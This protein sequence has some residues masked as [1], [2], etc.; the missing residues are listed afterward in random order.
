MP[1]HLYSHVQSLSYLYCVYS[2]S[3]HL[4]SPCLCPRSN[5]TVINIVE[6]GIRNTFFNIFSIKLNI[7]CGHSKNINRILCRM[8]VLKRG[9]VYSTHTYQIC[10]S[11]ITIIGSG[12]DVSIIIFFVHLLF[13]KFNNIYYIFGVAIKLD[14]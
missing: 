7:Y 12:E 6:M 5:L 8:K 10:L 11:M 9:V 1:N 4:Y 13:H 3:T 14:T 2:D